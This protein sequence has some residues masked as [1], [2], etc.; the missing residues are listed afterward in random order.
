MLA[1][2]TL[3]QLS[4]VKVISCLTELQGVIK[5]SVAQGGARIATSYG[6]KSPGFEF[7]EGNEIFSSK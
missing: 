1:E 7:R 2:G 6:L 5:P 4:E 3:K